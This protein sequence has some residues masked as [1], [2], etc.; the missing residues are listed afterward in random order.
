MLVFLASVEDEKSRS[1]LEDL[2][3]RYSRDKMAESIE[4]MK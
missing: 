1:I 2:D 3:T 4:I